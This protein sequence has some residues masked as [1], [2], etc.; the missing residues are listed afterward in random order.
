MDLDC[1]GA[2]GEVVQ[3]RSA[4]SGG[5]PTPLGL[6]NADQDAGTRKR[7]TL[8]IRDVDVKGVVHL[9][10]QGSFDSIAVLDPELGVA[11]SGVVSERDSV[12]P[13]CQIAQFESAVIVGISD[14]GRRRIRGS[15]GLPQVDPSL[16]ERA[17]SG[18]YGL[19]ADGSAPVQEDL[20]GGLSGG[21]GNLDRIGTVP[22]RLDQ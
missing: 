8:A 17:A 22:R 1:M 2:G 9:G 15:I 14:R 4:V 21:A 10:L 7:E 12:A 19:T 18:G 6:V 20:Q 16:R 13:G 11:Q 3:A 5:K